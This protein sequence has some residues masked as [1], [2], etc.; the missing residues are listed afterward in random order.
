MHSCKKETKLCGE[1]WE[2]HFKHTKGERQ[3]EGRERSEGSSLND[4]NEAAKSQG[5]MAALISRRRQGRRCHLQSLWE[6]HGSADTLIMAQ[7]FYLESS[8]L[9][10]YKRINVCCFKPQFPW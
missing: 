3:H 10:K 8:G 6:E 7:G 2:G 5:G 9:Q 1:G 4:R